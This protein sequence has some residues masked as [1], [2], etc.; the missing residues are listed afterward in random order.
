MATKPR[1]R[2]RA[3]ARVRLKP[4]V[5]T[6]VQAGPPPPA[7]THRE[8]L[9]SLKR[10]AGVPVGECKGIVV[11][12]DSSG[13]AT[14]WQ[15][16]D[17]YIPPCYDDAQANEGPLGSMVAVRFYRCECGATLVVASPPVGVARLRN[18]YHPSR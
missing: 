13:A 15:R 7:I 10:P 3:R 4:Q 2:V 16:A 17:P 8:L 11:Q 6:A 9:D 1:D 18:E 12:V 5:E 14:Q